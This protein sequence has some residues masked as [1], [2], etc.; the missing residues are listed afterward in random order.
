MRESPCKMSG[1]L[2][3]KDERGRLLRGFDL[4]ADGQDGHCE[5]GERGVHAVPA[6]DSGPAA[7]Q[8]SEDRG[9]SD[10]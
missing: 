6:S 1:D 3:G 2:G 4:S 8:L 10:Q 9:P 5:R 7:C